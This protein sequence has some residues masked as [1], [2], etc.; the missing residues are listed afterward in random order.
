[1]SKQDNIILLRTKQAEYQLK[2]EDLWQAFTLIIIGIVPL[3][4]SV[5]KF[6]N[7]L[8]AFIISGLFFI[9][10]FV[11]ALYV[12]VNKIVII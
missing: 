6:L 2:K 4:I 11:V 12:F 8:H 1:M 5:F 10:T 7:S 9:I 3:F